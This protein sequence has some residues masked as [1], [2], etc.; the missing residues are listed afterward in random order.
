MPKLGMIA[1]DG[2]KC[3]AII[4]GVEGHWG[5]ANLS[6]QRACHNIG[7]SRSYWVCY[8]QILFRPPVSHLRGPECDTPK[9]TSNDTALAELSF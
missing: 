4:K 3:L 5:S 2:C 1:G 7:C 9:F 6:F 8:T